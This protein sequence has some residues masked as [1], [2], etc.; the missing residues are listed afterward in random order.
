[1]PVSTGKLFLPLVLLETVRGEGLAGAEGAHAT[2]P[3]GGQRRW[4]SNSTDSARL[5]KAGE[6]TANRPVEMPLQ[7]WLG[8]AQQH[9]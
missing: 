4:P 2:A 3:P 1:M 6:A 9:G 5:P 8:S 7:S